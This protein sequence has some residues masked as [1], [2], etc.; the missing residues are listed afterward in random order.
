MS[1]VLTEDELQ[2]ITGAGTRVTMIAWLESNR[3]PYLLAR[4]GWPRVHVKAIEYAFGVSSM[5]APAPDAI[6]FEGFQ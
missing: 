5:S 2:P 6:S 4:S 1:D 3:I